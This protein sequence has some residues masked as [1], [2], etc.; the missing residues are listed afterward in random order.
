MKPIK[1]STECYQTVEYISYSQ[2]LLV[3]LLYKRNM[4]N[5]KLV[6]TDYERI[7]TSS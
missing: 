4:T 3:S 6:M 1:C 2:Q 5:K 7:W